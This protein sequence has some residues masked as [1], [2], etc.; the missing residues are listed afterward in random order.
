MQSS[1][2][3]ELCR[4]MTNFQRVSGER[5]CRGT[6]RW[7]WTAT[8]DGRSKEGW[9]LTRV[10]M[11]GFTLWLGSWVFVASGVSKLPPFSCSPPKTGAAPQLVN[12]SFHSVY[13]PDYAHQFWFVS[14]FTY[15]HIWFDLISYISLRTCT[16]ITHL[17]TL[18]I[19]DEVWFWSVQ[20]FLNLG[21][22][23]SFKIRKIEWNASLLFIG[24]TLSEEW[25]QK[26]RSLFIGNKLDNIVSYEGIYLVSFQELSLLR[27]E[28]CFLCFSCSC[29]KAEIDFV[30]WR[31]QKMLVDELDNFMR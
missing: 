26:M 1:P 24:N 3:S 16:V 9:S 18:Y 5:W 13:L 17:G 22:V 29:W 10:M 6:W 19:L 4:R 30:M 21:L 12:L 27:P 8:R 25:E 14:A 23:W 7:Y 28:V 15:K 20:P 31:F 2:R 11:P